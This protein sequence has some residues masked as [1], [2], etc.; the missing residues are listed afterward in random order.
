MVVY[1]GVCLLRR[2]ESFFLYSLRV[3]VALFLTFF[4]CLNPSP[5][6]DIHL[7]LYTTFFLSV[8]KGW[9]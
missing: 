4:K 3:C 2:I 9:K 8:L 7:D 6:I 1:V 5:T